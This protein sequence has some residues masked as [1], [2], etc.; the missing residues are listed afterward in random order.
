[1]TDAGAP[2]MNAMTGQPQRLADGSTN[3]VG[4]RIEG[5]YKLDDR[6][7]VLYAVDFAHQT[8]HRGQP[9][10]G[11]RP[12]TTTPSSAWPTRA[13]GCARST[14]SAQGTSDDPATSEAFQTP[15][16]H[17]WDGWTENFLRTPKTGLRLL[18]AHLAG[19]VPGVDG[20]TL[21]GAYY[22]L[23]RR[24]HR[25]AQRD[26]GVRR[27]RSLRPR[28]RRRPR[29]SL[30]QARQEPGWSAARV[31]YYKDDKLKPPQIPL[32]AANLRTSAYTMYAF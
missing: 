22:R 14:T 10:R 12:T 4:T 18:A 24:H 29:V 21:T 31:A 20:L 23:L 7:G 16:S 26:G 13:S 6:W 5:P 11:R 28:A 15:L 9:A 17:P 30:R 32:G 25:A 19:P 1:M 27:W 8:R 3:S 2:M